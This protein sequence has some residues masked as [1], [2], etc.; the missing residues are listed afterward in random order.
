MTSKKKIEKTEPELTSLTISKKEAESLI[1]KRIAIGFELINTKINDETAYKKLQTDSQ[2]WAK[3]NFEL[4]K[5]I[6][7]NDSIA[8]E[9]G[10]Y[11]YSYH[12]L[13]SSPHQE[14]QSLKDS[15]GSYNDKLDSVKERLILIPELNSSKS[16]T[17]IE[18]VHNIDKKIGK[19]IFIVHGRNETFKIEVESFLKTLGLNPIVLHEKP[20]KGRTIIEK[21]ENYSNVDFAIVIL[22]SDD[23]GRIKNSSAEFRNRA[24]QNVILELGFFLGKLGR[25]KVCVLY[26]AG[27]E[28]PSDY[29][30]VLYVSLNEWHIKLAKE[31][32]H[33]GIDIDLN[34]II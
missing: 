20:N 15:I 4:L 10:D 30:G 24:R 12:S 28:L 13:N 32:K 31:I 21:F 2:K 27:I 26:E 1:S 9:C 25:E 14:L 18:N 3:F 33:A 6:F 11:L 17:V 16:Q 29:D 23:E 5:R 22:T 8:K 7:D 19:D 34:K